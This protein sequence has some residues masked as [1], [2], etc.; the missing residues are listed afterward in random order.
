MRD[1][2]TTAREAGSVF[3]LVY[4]SRSL[5]DGAARESDLAAI[6]ASARANNG[7]LGITGALLVWQDAF[8][9]VLEGDEAAVRAVYRVIRRDERHERVR[10]VDADTVPD[11]VFARWSMARVGDDDGVDIPV[12]MDRPGV[13]DRPGARLVPD[14]PILG[15]PRQ[16]TLLDLMRDYA[17]APRPAG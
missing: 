10:L 11:R 1:D 6:L 4:R 9:Q 16:G 15:D 2:G 14:A 8:V 3:R 12:A 13:A 7:R 17:R 5:L